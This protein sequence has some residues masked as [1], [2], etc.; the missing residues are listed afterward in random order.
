MSQLTTLRDTKVALDYDLSSF[1]GISMD[2]IDAIMEIHR[3]HFKKKDALEITDAERD[4]LLQDK[5]FQELTE[6]PHLRWGF[7]YTGAVVL[8]MQLRDKRSVDFTHHIVNTYID[9]VCL[10][11]ALELLAQTDD[12]E[13]RETLTHDCSRLMSRVMAGESEEVS[14]KI[15]P[16][17]PPIG[18]K[19]ATSRFPPFSHPE[20]RYD[21]ITQRFWLT[22][23]EV[24]ILQDALDDSKPALVVGKSGMVN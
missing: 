8:M 10:R 2:E 5:R 19:T 20:K 17:V 7:T 18:C 3:D 1:F 13:E 21:P 16:A 12:A 14:F 24:D 4:K 6:K 22:P 9:V 11:G 23:E 15:R